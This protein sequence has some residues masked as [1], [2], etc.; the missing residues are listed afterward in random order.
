MIYFSHLLNDEDMKEIIKDTHMG[1]EGIEFSIAENLDCFEDTLCSYK[2]RLKNMNC[3]NLIL[4]GPFLDLNPMAYDRLIVEATKKRYEQAY[5]AA[6][7]LGASRIIFHS[8]Y[9]PSVYFLTGWADRM[10]DF[11]NR[12]LEDKGD[13]IEILMENVLD[14]EPAPLLEVAQ[15]VSHPAFGLCLD[16][17]HAHCYSKASCKEWAETLAPQLRHLHIHDNLGDRDS[18][19]AIGKGNIP[20]YDILAA[21]DGRADI[22]CTIECNLKEDVMESFRRLCLR[23]REV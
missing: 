9:V 20:F 19:L 13:S 2:E 16:V 12:F 6:E 8:G 15:K 18:H 5:K 3:K 4:H 10:A 17:G 21:Q 7:I 14:P 11:Y 23:P 22:S 1:V